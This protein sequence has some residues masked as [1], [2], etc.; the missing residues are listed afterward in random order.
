[1]AASRLDS[2]SGNRQRCEVKCGG[3]SRGESVAYRKLN[4]EC[5]EAM[6]LLYDVQEGCSTFSQPSE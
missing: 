5:D 1:M 3:P 4:D 6:L 2:V